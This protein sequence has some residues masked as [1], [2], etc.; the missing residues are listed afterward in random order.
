MPSAEPA[1]EAAADESLPGWPLV[2]AFCEA[3]ALER[4]ASPHT[5]R[6]YRNDLAAY[7]RWAHRM[8]LDPDRKSTRLNSSHP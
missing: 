6:S 5:V 4:G 7:L 3:I 2:E 1:A 8:Q